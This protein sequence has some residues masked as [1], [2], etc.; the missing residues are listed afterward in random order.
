MIEG[1][2][3]V[4]VITESDSLELVKAFNGT[5]QVRQRFSDCFQIALGLVKYW[6]NTAIGRQTTWCT[7][8]ARHVFVSN[9]CV[10]WDDDPPSF[11]VPDIINDVPLFKLQ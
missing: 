6:C 7:T 4:P 8:L 9:A 5:I 1:L 10:F 11:I 3:C 2:G